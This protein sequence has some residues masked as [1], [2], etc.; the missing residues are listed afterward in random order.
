MD[1]DSINQPTFMLSKD[2]S[3]LYKA[4]PALARL[5]LVRKALATARTR[6]QT[7]VLV[8]PTHKA[9]KDGFVAIKSEMSEG[10]ELAPAIDD[11]D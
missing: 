10:C 4:T 2:S 9:M 3:L 11:L 8:A 7:D 6:N 5:K 1:Y